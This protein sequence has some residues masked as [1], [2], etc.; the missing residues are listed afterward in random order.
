MYIAVYYQNEPVFVCHAKY[1]QAAKI[2]LDHW[3]K[4]SEASDD[5]KIVELQFDPFFQGTCH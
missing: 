5:F 1:K 4:K 3:V 2:V